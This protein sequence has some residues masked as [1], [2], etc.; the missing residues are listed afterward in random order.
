MLIHL[1]CYNIAGP[2]NFKTI[3]HD[4]ISHSVI[5]EPFYNQYIAGRSLGGAHIQKTYFE[6]IGVSGWTT[7]G[8][9]SGEDQW[10][11]HTVPDLEV[12]GITSV[13]LFYPGFA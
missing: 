10:V 4:S 2:I 3:V 1:L 12:S 9:M 8:I 7:L 11:D 6:A 13:P 5:L